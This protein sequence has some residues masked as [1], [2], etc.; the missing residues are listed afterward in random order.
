MRLHADVPVGVCLSGGLDSSAMLGIATELTGKPLE[1]FHL[2]FEGA[3]G[4][5]ERQ[6]AEIAAQHNRANLH[7]VV[8]RLVRHGR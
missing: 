8:G 6:Y 7:C 2:S 1:A 3:E 5:D 4:F